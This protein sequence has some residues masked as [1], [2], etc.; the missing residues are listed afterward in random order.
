MEERERTKRPPKNTIVAV[1]FNGKLEWHCEEDSPPP[2]PHHHHH[3]ESQHR[4]VYKLLAAPSM[5]HVS[6]TA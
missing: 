5:P 1:H 2:P 4:S 6:S 3:L